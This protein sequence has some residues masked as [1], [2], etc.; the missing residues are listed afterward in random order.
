VLVNDGFHGRVGSDG[1]GAT[2]LL[3]IGA[4]SDVCGAVLMVL[5]MYVP[6]AAAHFAIFD[7]I[8]D[9]SAIGIEANDHDFAAVGALHLR[10]GVDNAVTEREFFVE[11][12]IHGDRR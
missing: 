8:G 5:D 10:F 6:R 2:Q 7:I 11:G 3:V 12:I 4:Q 1:I 9:R